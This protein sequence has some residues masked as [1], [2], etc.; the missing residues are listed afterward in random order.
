MSTTVDGAS[1]QDRSCLSVIVVT[2]KTVLTVLAALHIAIVSHVVDWERPRVTDGIEWGLRS[3]S[4]WGKI[5]QE[6][7]KNIHRKQS[8]LKQSLKA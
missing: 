8:I 2:Y 5:L 4:V 3:N 6:N 1:S 7:D